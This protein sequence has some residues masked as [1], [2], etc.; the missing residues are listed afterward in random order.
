MDIQAKNRKLKRTAFIVIVIS[1]LIT[2]VAYGF[3]S[4]HLNRTVPVKSNGLAVAA[5]PLPGSVLYSVDKDTDTLVPITVNVDGKA[6]PALDAQAGPDGSWYFILN[7]L[8]PNPVTNLYVRAKDGT[9]KKL[10]TSQTAKYNLSYDPESGKLIYQ[11]A[12]DPS[13]PSFLMSPDWNLTVYDP[14][15]GNEQVVGVGLNPILLPGGN[16]FLFAEGGDL[17]LG[18]IDATATSSVVSVPSG[19]YA[20]DAASGKLAVYNDV[21]HKVDLYTLTNGA[22]ASYDSSPDA[23]SKPV[24]LAYINGILMAA[25]VVDQSGTKQYVFSRPDLN[26][27]N[28]IIVGAL[29][30]GAPQRLYAYE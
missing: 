28:P 2:I 6:L 25:N 18:S 23:P 16:S 10:T 8:G 29:S 15:T 13:D 22:S 30:N 9:V 19:I 14:A 7:E 17:T 4:L 11:V 12:I 27:L 3:P 5:G 26:D 1:G 20:V 21:T 24:V